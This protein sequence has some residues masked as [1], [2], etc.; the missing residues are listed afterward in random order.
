[1]KARKVLEDLMA[2]VY[3]TDREEQERKVWAQRRR[4]EERERRRALAARDF[5][6]AM[7]IRGRRR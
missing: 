3:G 4:I 5:D 1:M 6:E 7:N 2:K